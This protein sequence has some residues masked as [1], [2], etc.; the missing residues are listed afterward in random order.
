MAYDETLATRVRSLLAEQAGV[1]ERKMFGGLAFMVRGHM[2]CGVLDT[3][4]IVRVGP[5]A[6]EATLEE[7]HVRTMEVSGR[8]MRGMVFV[9]SRGVG[10]DTAL[11]AWVNKALGYVRTL[12]PKK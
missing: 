8:P 1:S 6:Y 12:E 3:D 5:E 4:L 11:A 2:V 9:A 10:R 7:S